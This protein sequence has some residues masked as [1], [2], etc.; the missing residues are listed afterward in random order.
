MATH[1]NITHPSSYRKAKRAPVSRLSARQRGTT[2]PTAERQSAVSKVERIGY[3][4]VP[5]RKTRGKKA[6]F[7][8]Y[9]KLEWEPWTR[10]PGMRPGGGCS[11]VIWR[12]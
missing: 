2:L 11:V 7:N 12:G 1:K 9:S 4:L 5:H 8:N 10:E 6:T 3:D